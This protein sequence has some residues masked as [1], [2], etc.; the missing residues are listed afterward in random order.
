M[1]FTPTSILHSCAIT[2]ET[3]PGGRR[4]TVKSQH[5][6]VIEYSTSLNQTHHPKYTI[7]VNGCVYYSE[8]DYGKANRDIVSFKQAILSVHE[9]MNV[10]EEERREEAKKGSLLRA[11]TLFEE[12][13]G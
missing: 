6:D 2:E 3:I 11:Q 4:F 12:E 13:G 8:T 7:V 9:H 1:N 5:G 10:Q